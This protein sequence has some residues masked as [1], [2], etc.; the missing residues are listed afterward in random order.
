MTEHAVTENY[1]SEICDEYLLKIEEILKRN[2]GCSTIEGPD[3]NT[4]PWATGKNFMEKLKNKINDYLTSTENDN[5]FILG[6]ILETDTR[7][8][9]FGGIKNFFGWDS[10][11]ITNYGNIY[12]FGPGAS[13][14]ENEL[15]KDENILIPGK[16]GKESTELFGRDLYVRL[17]KVITIN[18]KLFDF[19][20]DQIK[21][22]I[23]LTNYFNNGDNSR[24]LIY[25]PYDSNGINYSEKNNLIGFQGIGGMEINKKHRLILIENWKTIVNNHI[26]IITA[27]N[28]VLEEPVNEPP[29]DFLCPITYVIM[30]DPVI[31]MDGYT[32]ER[33][34]IETW[35]RANQTSPMTNVVLDDTLTLI[36][37]FTMRSL[38]ASWNQ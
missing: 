19:E 14:T 22:N 7:G 18:Q 3:Y 23:L 32:Y 10:Y 8:V 37:N 6:F 31:A 20:I 38:I 12:K 34:A 21:N 5:E 15:L 25:Y 24:S 28:I 29:D 1:G 16:I 9:A 30:D 36:P 4:F 35:F 27:R 13:F 11:L 26:H 2:W 33:L 17:V